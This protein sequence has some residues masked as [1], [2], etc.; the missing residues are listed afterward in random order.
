[1]ATSHV[2]MAALQKCGV[3]GR[4]V[5]RK[6]AKYNGLINEYIFVPAAFETLGPQS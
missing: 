4:D 6:K 5:A 2:A 3:A 1:M